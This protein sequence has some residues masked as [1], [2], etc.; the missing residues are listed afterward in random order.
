[1]PSPSAPEISQFSPRYVR[2]LKISIAVMSTL[3]VLGV[4][5]LI[6][7]MA[8]Q[9]SRIGV[10]SP[11]SPSTNGPYRVS[12]PL[13]A[14]EVKSVVLNGELAIVTWKGQDGETLVTFDLK[15][16]REIGRVALSPA[17]KP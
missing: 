2:I 12:L 3:I 10:K 14:G 17:N 11:A 9:A 16:G 1:M 8:R 13:G 6:Y 4:A 7:G 5:A 15:T